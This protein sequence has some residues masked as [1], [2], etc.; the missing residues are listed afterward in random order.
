M[1]TRAMFRMIPAELQ[2]KVIEL[3]AAERCPIVLFTGPQLRHERFA[4]RM[5][6]EFPGL[7]VAWIQVAPPGEQHSR[8]GIH[9]VLS[10]AIKFSRMLGSTEGRAVAIP[11]LRAAAKRAGQLLFR[12]AKRKAESQADAERRLFG[13]EIKQL[14]KTATLTPICIV[15]ANSEETIAFVKS[16]DPYFVLTL[17]GAIYGR[18]L[19]ECAKGLALNQHDGWCP[20]Y[21]GSDTVDWA[22]YHRDLAKVGNTVH[23]LTAGM[24]SG[25]ILRR[26]TVCLV[27][28]DTPETCFARSV[29]LGTELLCEIVRELIETKKA[30]VFPQ[31]QLT[32]QTFLRCEMT[33]D[34]RR[35]VRRD[36][37]RN[38]IRRDIERRTNF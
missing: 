19:C 11:H 6:A 16:L 17:G 25:P 28:D 3:P 32:G 31:P 33:D 18:A 29:A 38:L 34:I 10:P 1:Q 2:C 22:L 20:E 27:E 35:D 24:D 36:L 12:S 37:Q 7:V 26:S 30:R 13:E 4:L 21:R 8:Y 9:D 15:D 23:I 5:Q 14:R